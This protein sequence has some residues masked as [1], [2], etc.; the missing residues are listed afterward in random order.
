[1]ESK[2][3]NCGC[4]QLTLSSTSGPQVWSNWTLGRWRA[5][6]PKLKSSLSSILYK[7][8]L[9]CRNRCRH[10]LL[11]LLLRQCTQ[12]QKQVK[13]GCILAHS[14]RSAV[15][16]G[17]EAMAGVWG[18]WAHPFHSE[19]AED[20]GL[21]LSLLSPFFF[22]S[23]CQFMEWSLTGEVGCFTSINVIPQ[24]HVQNLSARLFCLQSRWQHQASDYL[25]KKE[26]KSNI[27]G[28]I[29][30]LTFTVH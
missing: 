3:D 1:M 19:A 18:H 21:L 4:S 16:E 25:R 17:G 28:K 7:A 30:I 11:V 5:E 20:N 9:G 12:W 24:G 14:S 10:E 13:T 22:S 6:P 15:C 26:K 23:G 27:K 29:N 8:S 2:T